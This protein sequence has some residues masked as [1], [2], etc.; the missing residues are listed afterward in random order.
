MEVHRNIEIKDA[1]V[2]VDGT[3]DFS[4]PERNF[5]LFAKQVYKHYQ[6]D[7]SKFFK[8][9]QLCKLGFLTSEILLKGIHLSDV[10]AE[11]VSL[12]LANSSSSLHS[13]I[14]YQRTIETTP[15]PSSF[16][17][18]LPNILIGE[19]CIRHGIK[20][21]GTFFI[22]DRFEKDFIFDYVSSL[23]KARKTTMSIVGWVD[24]DMD[25]SYIADLYLLKST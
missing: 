25:G 19:I 20:G 2:Q 18:T 5:N 14:E 9:S 1:A 16:V 24:I 4:Y 15:R 10:E 13:D 11:M 12:I 8:M 6:I 21:E 23:F 17:Y 7:Y 3:V 22:Q